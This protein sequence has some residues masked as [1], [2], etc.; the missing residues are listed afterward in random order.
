MDVTQ[1]I[2]HTVDTDIGELKQLVSQPADVIFVFASPAFFAQPALLNAISEQSAIVV[3]CST[4]GEITAFDALEDTAVIT[5]INLEETGTA[6]IHL[7]SVDDEDYH[8][9]GKRIATALDDE[10][11]RAMVVLTRGMNFLPTGLFRGIHD[12][13]GEQVLLCGGMA[14]DNARYVRTFLLTPEGISDHKIVAVGFYGETLCASQAVIKGWQP[15]GPIRQVTRSEGNILF[16]LDGQPA[17]DVYKKYL[18]DYASQLPVSGLLFPLEMMNSY[19]ETS[20]LLRALY[21]IDE[22]TG[23]LVLGGKIK[24]GAYLRL[25]HASTN[26]LISDVEDAAAAFRNT[27]SPQMKPGF[28]LVVSCVA[29]KVVMGDQ[30]E[31]EIEALSSAFSEH[32]PALGFYSNGEFGPQSANAG[33]KLHNQTMIVTLFG[34]TADA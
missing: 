25:N 1:R 12:V 19:D 2:I 24:Q 31:E 16:E 28:A 26:D 14:G 27:L 15:F 5:V 8:S 29:R 7:D 18:G 30:V 3:G 33:C 11:L 9:C 21:D 6:R 32:I 17:L 34:A 22:S 20:G 10:Y 4:S 23:S 13:L